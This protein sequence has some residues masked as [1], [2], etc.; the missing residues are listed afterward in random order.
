MQGYWE[1]A[2]A[3][4]EAF[5]DGWSRNGGLGLFDEEGYLHIVDRIKDIIIVGSS[6]VYP[7]DLETVLSDCT[8]ICEA[9]VVGR[10]DDRLAR[11]RSPA[12]CPSPAVR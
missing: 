12:S 10:R 5:R 4:R 8:D 3:T 9:A 6:N 2:Q 1:N 11:C 7:S